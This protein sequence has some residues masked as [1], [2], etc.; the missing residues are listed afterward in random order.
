MFSKKGQGLPIETLIIIL[1]A[2]IVLI[3]VVLFFSGSSGEIFGTV[4][5]FISSIGAPK[6]N[7]T[8]VVK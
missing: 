3:I 1:I 8:D 7:Y 6:L 2:I 4:K 5:D